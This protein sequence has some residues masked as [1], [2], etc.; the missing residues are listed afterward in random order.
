MLDSTY[1]DAKTVEL[2]LSTDEGIT[3]LRS[4][5]WGHQITAEFSDAESI[6]RF[7]YDLL[8]RAGNDSVTVGLARRLLG[9][10]LEDLQIRAGLGGHGEGSS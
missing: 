8:T 3:T 1:Y 9:D 7:A 10:Y 4:D 5:A 2:T 6:V